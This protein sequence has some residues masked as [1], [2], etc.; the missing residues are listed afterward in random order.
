VA[1]IAE[2]LGFESIFYG[3]HPVTPVGD[4]GNSVH[5]K[6]VPFFQ[7]TLVAL[8]RASAVTRKIKLGGGVFLMPLH[9]PVLFAKQLATLDF[10]SG[11]RLIVGAGAGWSRVQCEVMGGNFDRRWAQTREAIQVMK[12][13]W[14]QDVAEFRGEFFNVAPISIYPKPVSKQGPPVLLPG[15]PNE[16]DDSLESPQWLRAFK[17]IVSY[18]DG[19]YPGRMGNAGMEAGPDI[20]VRGRKILERLCKEA[21]RDPRELQIS[22][23]L[24]TEIHDGDLTWPELVGKDVLR[25]YADVGV[26]RVVITIP[27]LTS[28]ENA[29]EV[30]TRM[31]DAILR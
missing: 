9:Q 15:P 6:G 7:D 24:R 11:G 26:E 20:I 5:S 2:E 4:P 18:A 17:R 1:Q 23:L 28:S 30:M 12:M 27:T 13:L 16:A 3:E 29:R 8:A 31:A 14:T 19:W 21:G 10:Y 22:V 25:R